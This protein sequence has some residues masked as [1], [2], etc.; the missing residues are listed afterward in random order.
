MASV[1]NMAER[2]EYMGMER[3]LCKRP[4]GE[5][6]CVRDASTLLLPPPPPPPPPT[7]LFPQS[8]AVERDGPAN[9]EGG[10][11]R[12]GHDVVLPGRQFHRAV[13]VLAQVVVGEVDEFVRVHWVPLCRGG[14]R[15]AEVFV[16]LHG[17]V[18]QLQAAVA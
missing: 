12:S 13:G 7:D 5:S 10:A 8:L 11:D 16:F 18:R 9:E 1:Q 6:A 15:L 2:M 14:Q 3:L 17:V 4:R